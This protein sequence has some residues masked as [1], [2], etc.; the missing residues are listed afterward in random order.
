VQTPPP[1][2]RAPACEGVLRRSAPLPQRRSHHI[3][4]PSAPGGAPSPADPSPSSELFRT[5]RR[6]RHAPGRAPVRR[7]SSLTHLPHDLRTPTAGWGSAHRPR[8]AHASGHAAG[9]AS[10]SAP[11]S[12]AVHAR[13]GARARSLLWRSRRR[14]RP[15]SAVPARPTQMPRTAAPRTNT[16]LAHRRCRATQPNSHPLR[17]LCEEERLSYHAPS[18]YADS[19]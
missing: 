15:P 12:S 16:R 14:R 10:C 11:R 13:A 7:P 6:E 17:T 8:A 18:R 19:R 1:Q 5:L 4:S 3:A 2:R 9:P